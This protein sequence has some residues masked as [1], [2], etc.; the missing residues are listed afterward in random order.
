VRKVFVKQNAHWSA[1]CASEVSSA[2]KPVPVTDG[3]LMEELIDGVAALKIVEERLHGNA[4]ANNTGVPL[5]ISGRYGRPLAWIPLSFSEYTAG[6]FLL[7][8]QRRR[9]LDN[10][11]HFYDVLTEIGDWVFA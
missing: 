10:R 2:A 5:R 9:W 7:R 1:A 3:K 8:A 11:A 4:R 6:C